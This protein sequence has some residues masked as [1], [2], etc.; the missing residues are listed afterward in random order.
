MP[1][2]VPIEIPE[3]L[4]PLI[5]QSARYKIVYG[6]RGKGATWSFARCLLRLGMAQRER[7]L[8]AR[9][10]QRTI[11][12]SVHFVLKRQIEILGLEHFY[13]VKETEIVGLNGTTFIFAG[14]RDMDAAKLKSL[15]GVTRVWVAEAHVISDNSWR[16]LI[17]TIRE[18]DSEI[19]VEFNP[20]LA[21]DPTYERF[22]TNRR[23]DSLAIFMSWRDNPWFPDVLERERTQ[24]FDDDIED[25][26]PTYNYVWE[27]KPKPAVEGAIFANEVARFERDNRFRSVDCDPMGLVHGIMDLGYGVMTMTLAQRFAS[28]V[29]IVGYREWRN[30]TYDLITADLRNDQALKEYR[31]GNIFMPHDSAHK[32]PKT[33]ESHKAV[34]EALG[35]KVEDVPQI[36][37]ENYIEKGRRLFRSCYINTENGG[38]DLMNCLRR[39]KYNIPANA[40]TDKERRAPKKDDWSHGAESFC[41]TAVVADQLVNNPVRVSDPY[42]GF[43]RGYAA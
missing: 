23:H 32:D 7:I 24:D 21:T 36:G 22:I 30:S 33:G 10:I 37:I 29:Q 39:F 6:G 12:E 4:L 11:K 43:E 14:L 3:K 2:E 9:E 34:M 20:E 1:N 19:W 42:R 17:P 38:K 15:E 25:G 41:Y 18:P 40:D 13:T 5:Y 27:G 16:V 26:K 28:T 31:W 35:W 8:C